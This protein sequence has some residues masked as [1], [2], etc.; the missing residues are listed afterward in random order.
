MGIRVSPRPAGWKPP[1]VGKVK[2]KGKTK[3]KRK[4]PVGFKGGGSVKR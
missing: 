2:P 1:K 3:T 4:L